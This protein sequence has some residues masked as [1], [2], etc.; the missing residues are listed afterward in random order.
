LRDVLAGSVE[1]LRTTNQTGD[2][3]DGAF[4]SDSEE[5]S[6]QLAE[7]EA[8]ELNQ[9]ERA[10]ARLRLGQYGICEVCQKKI[11]VA[12]LNTLPYSTTCIKCQRAMEACPGSSG[13]HHENWGQIQDAEAAL[14]NQ[15]DADLENFER[16]LSS[17]P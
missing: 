13:R 10:L 12:R 17:D 5:I 14:E 3:A 11:P 1:N 8:R 6:T 2:S 15:R 4:D 9:I 7:L 16:S